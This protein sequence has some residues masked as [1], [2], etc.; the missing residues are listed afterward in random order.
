LAVVTYIHV[1][2]NRNS[3][4]ENYVKNDYAPVMKQAGVSYL[5]SQTI[6][7]G[8]ANEYITLTLRDSFTDLDKGPVLVQALGAEGAQKLT[9]KL[10]AGVVAHVERSLT[11]F[12][13]ELSIM[14]AKP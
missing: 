13:P 12:V 7:G 4:F 3:E 6:F 10:P 8:D 1:A 14:P 11:R 2:P 5:V 9:Q